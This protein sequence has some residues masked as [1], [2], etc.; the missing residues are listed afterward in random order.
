MSRLPLNRLFA[1]EGLSPIFVT[2]ASAI[3]LK[4]QIATQAWFAFGLIGIGISLVL[5]Q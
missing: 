5:F 4:E 1:F 3:F 2:A